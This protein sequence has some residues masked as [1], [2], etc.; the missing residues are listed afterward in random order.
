MKTFLHAF[1]ASLALLLILSFWVSSTVSEVFMSLDSVKW[2]KLYIFHAMIAL[3][4][5]LATLGI[6][7]FMLAKNKRH[8]LINKKRLRMPIIAINGLLVLLP[9][10]IYLHTK[11]SLEEFDASFYAIQCVELIGGLLNIVLIG[12]NM[13][14]GLRLGGRS[15]FFRLFSSGT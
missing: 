5:A 2:V 9:A 4:P 12:L 7:G 6:S 1:S 15:K 8:A 11:A 13:R 10:A 14:D 3:I